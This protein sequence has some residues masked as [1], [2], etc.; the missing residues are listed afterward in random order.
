MLTSGSNLNAD[1]DTNLYPQRFQ[2]SHLLD[3]VNN[4]MLQDQLLIFYM[5]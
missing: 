2:F 1:T 4:G 5:L 3:F